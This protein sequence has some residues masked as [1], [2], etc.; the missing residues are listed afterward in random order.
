MTALLASPRFVE[1]VIAA[2]IAAGAVLALY[3]RRT[4]RGVPPGDL[5]SFLGAGLALLVAMRAGAPPA[6]PG[7]RAVFAAAMAASLGCHVWHL[8]RRWDV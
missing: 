4:G 1:L 8:A 2:V 7:G 6:T 5:L 3:R